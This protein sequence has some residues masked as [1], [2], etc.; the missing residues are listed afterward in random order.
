MLPPA[1]SSEA[2]G[3]K[4]QTQ[5]EPPFSEPHILTSVAGVLEALP[6]VVGQEAR[7]VHPELVAGPIAGH[8]S[9]TIHTDVHTARLNYCSN[10]QLLLK[11]NL[12]LLPASLL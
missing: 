1:C 3:E 6:A 2:R 9:T 12:K 8:T 5:T 11:I 4:S 10:L 7:Y